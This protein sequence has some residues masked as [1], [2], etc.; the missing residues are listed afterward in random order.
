MVPAGGVDGRR[1]GKKWWAMAW[2]RILSV[3]LG[4]GVVLFLIQGHWL[5]RIGYPGLRLDLLL[6]LALQ[7]ALEMPFAFAVCWSL[8]W[9][10]VMDTFTGRLWGLHLGTYL[11]AMVL[12]YLA[13]ERFE[14]RNMA[15]RLVCVGLCALVEALV[16]GVYS[17]IVSA[18]PPYDPAIWLPLV[19]RILGVMVV[20]PLIGFPFERY[21]EQY[22][23]A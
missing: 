3:A 9:G 10:L 22:R 17:V 14:L 23:S 16:L 4:Y 12:V 20:T 7:V 2:F 6:P 13:E 15:Y 21:V 8:A 11:L 1:L 18:A 5:S 19:V